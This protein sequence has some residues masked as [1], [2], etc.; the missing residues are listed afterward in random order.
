MPGFQDIYKKLQLG[1]VSVSQNNFISY[2]IE[3]KSRNMPL[4]QEKADKL[5]KDLEVVNENICLTNEIIQAGE[6]ADNET[7]IELISTLKDMENKIIKLVEKLEDMEV[8]EYCLLIK[9]ELQETLSKYESL[10]QESLH[11][12]NESYIFHDKIPV[13]EAPNPVISNN[14]APIQDLLSDDSHPRE[15]IPNNIP[16]PRF[17]ALYPSVNQNIDPSIQ[18][19]N[20][21]DFSESHSKNIN[22]RASLDPFHNLVIFQEKDSST[23]SNPESINTTLSRLPQN[24]SNPQYNMSSIILQPSPQLIHPNMQSSYPN[25]QYKNPNLQ[26]ENPNTLLID[27]NQSININPQQLKQPSIDLNQKETTSNYSQSYPIKNSL[28]P[29]VE[30]KKNNFDELFDFKF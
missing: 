19:L 27:S 9:D 13:P 11:K 4:S 10:K 30:E 7:L 12:E 3:N 21:L 5:R 2:Q 25:Q 14:S 8:L 22:H 29:N 18:A 20:E 15:I 28:N 6:K 17:S 1:R 24:I 16:N 26:Y 23:H